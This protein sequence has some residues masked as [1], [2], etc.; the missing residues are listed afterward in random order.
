MNV[1]SRVK[2]GAVVGAAALGLGLLSS[3]AS[4]DPS[5]ATDYR[6]LTGVGSDTTQHVMNGLSNSTA[7]T[8]AGGKIIASWN[9]TGTATITTKA[10]GCAGITRPNGSVLGVSALNRDLADGT[11]C[12][13]FARSALGPVDASSTDLTWIPFAR[14]VVTYATDLGSPLPPNL[15]TEQLTDIY[16]CDSTEFPNAQPLLPH[17]GSGT[18]TLWLQALGMSEADVGYCV[19]DDIQPNDGVQIANGSQLMPYSVAQWI[20]QGKGFAD[21][22]NR[23]GQSRVRSINGFAPITGTGPA[24]ALNTNFDAKYLHDVYNVVPTENLSDAVITE[25]FLR[26]NSKVCRDID[27]IQAYGFGVITRWCGDTTL[28]GER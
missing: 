18:R 22:P 4:A 10:T 26:S 19:N 23:R 1:K 14:D 8:N 11:G 2:A 17:S 25:T 7:V 16:E 28:K 5:P 3:P 15:T 24:L 27:T 21:V 20:S 6:Q 12:I 13:D 9:A